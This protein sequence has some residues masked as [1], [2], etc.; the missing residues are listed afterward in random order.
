VQWAIVDGKVAYDKE[1]EMFFAHIRPRKKG[2]PA[3][4]KLDKGETAPKPEEAAKQEGD[5]QADGEKPKEGEQP[6]HG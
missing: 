5:K 4:V 2:E 3:D 6:K 1:K